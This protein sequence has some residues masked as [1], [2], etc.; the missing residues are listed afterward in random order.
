MWV[1]IPMTF[2][3]QCRVP[4][5]FLL[6]VESSLEESVSNTTLTQNKSQC[7]IVDVPGEVPKHAFWIQ[8]RGAFRH[9][10]DVFDAARRQVHFF[11]QLVIGGYIILGPEVLGAERLSIYLPPNKHF[12]SLYTK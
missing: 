3:Y 10:C 4:E 1:A 6:A 2:Y 9:D 8:V 5:D 7:V 12:R 11:R